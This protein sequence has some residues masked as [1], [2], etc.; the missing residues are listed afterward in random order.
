MSEGPRVQAIVRRVFQ[1]TPRLQGAIL[2]VPEEVAR[3]YDK[4]GQYVVLHPR[5]T[6]K[7]FLVIASAVGEARA[8][9]VL[10]GPAAAEKAKLTEG[11]HLEIDPPTGRGFGLDDAPGK[12][13][14]LF[15]VGTGVAALRPVIES[16][17]RRRTEFGDVVLYAGAHLPEEHPY[18]RDEEAWRRDSVRV[19]RAVSK[20]WVQ[21][22]F[23]RD[24]VPVS[25]ALAFVSGMKP[26]IEGVTETL[27]EHGMPRDRVRL[28]W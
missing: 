20:P 1:E 8:F 16:I 21:D 28:N 18:R 9:E 2:E 26:M 4:P 6:D 12:D 11:H 14:L 3:A 25:N 15:G 23:R 5:P 17:R 10:L 7:I 27:A 13:L 22:L 19:V 24:P